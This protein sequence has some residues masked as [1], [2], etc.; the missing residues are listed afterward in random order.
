MNTHKIL[1]I[2]LLIFLPFTVKGQEQR[3]SD[4]VRVEGVSQV[5]FKITRFDYDNLQEQ[6]N[7][8]QILINE[9]QEGYN[10]QNAIIKAIDRFYVKNGDS[11]KDIRDQI[12]R[13]NDQTLEN[14]RSHNGST[15][16][17]IIALVSIVG[18]IIP[19]I[20]N[21]FYRA[22]L[23][24]LENRNEETRVTIEKS[25]K[26]IEDFMQASEESAA[27][28]KISE[29]LTAAQMSSTALERIARYI[30]ALEL[31]NER[32]EFYNQ[33]LSAK[34]ERIEE[35]QNKIMYVR[36][37]KCEANI[38]LGAE[39]LDN[40]NPEE[41]IKQF[42]KALDIDNKDTIIYNNR[43][44]AFK[45]L[46]NSD[47]CISDYMKIL[48]LDPHSDSACSAIAAYY[49]E[50]KLYDQ[51]VEWFEKAQKINPAKV[52]YYCNRGIAYY[53]WGKE[54]EA[55][56]QLNL[57]NAIDPDYSDA[58]Y[59]SGI[60]YSEKGENEKAISY[61]DIAIIKSNK[62]YKSYLHRG[63]AKNDIG[64]LT[65]AL[66]D[67]NMAIML[68]PNNVMAY[69]NRG[70][71]LYHNSDYLAAIFDWNMVLNIDPSN[72]AAFFNRGNAYSALHRQDLALK[73][74]N[75]ALEMTPDSY[76]VYLMRGQ[77][78]SK[79]NDKTKA[80]SDFLHA[81]ELA[82]DMRES[83]LVTRAVAYKS[84]KE[85]DAAL[86]DLDELLVMQPNR[87]DLISI[88]CEVLYKLNRYDEVL[89]NYVSIVT[90]DNGIIATNLTGVSLVRALTVI[91][92]SY[93]KKELFI[94]ALKYFDLAVNFG[95]VDFKI[96][97]LRYKSIKNILKAANDDQKKI[98]EKRLL[99]ENFNMRVLNLLNK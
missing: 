10:E 63:I 16:N 38:N 94:E 80:E 27:N 50:E 98:L 41:A 49:Y 32:E 54:K 66:A 87:I 46:G 89:S 59:N 17:W 84:L 30:Q 25:V 68:E 92:K 67:Y 82:P 39:L 99:E 81:L 60:L 73:D 71:A 42:D 78:Y 75:M 22:N 7:E 52:E 31:L 74:Y 23:K 70:S 64:D 45:Q 93:F 86:S 34:N 44:I 57:A 40:N 8:Y 90:I 51:S 85:Y 3:I 62:D 83:I 5:P 4:S 72:A 2:L 12:F 61:F 21:T 56:N 1:Q 37:Q 53:K 69:I 14:V 19:L 26:K 24:Q 36:K 77:L 65:G 79:L 96:Y 95:E 18:L 76:P 15:V 28:S 97:E 91:A 48:E 58:Y 11:Y 33:M 29:I 55:I 6:L 9:L 88:R 13:D 35:V 43:A 47:D 20:I